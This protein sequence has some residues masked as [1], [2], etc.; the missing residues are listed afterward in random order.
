[1]IWIITMSQRRKISCGREK[2]Q[3]DLCQVAL[4]VYSTV[5][6]YHRFWYSEV[7][8]EIAETEAEP[9]G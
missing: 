9:Q 4:C 5:C 7:E 1:M 6:C 2:I 8:A 3:I